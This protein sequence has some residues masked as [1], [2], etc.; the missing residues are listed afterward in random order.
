V[1]SGSPSTGTVA[2]TAPAPATGAAVQ[3][4][5]SGD[6]FN[7]DADL[8]PVVIV[9]AGAT[10]ATFPVRTHM[11]NS[12]ASSVQEIIVGNYFGGSFQGAYLTITP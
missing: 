1:K 2:L 5:N 7:L 3:L 10:S 4:S 8:P 11:S 9:P 12:V 6:F